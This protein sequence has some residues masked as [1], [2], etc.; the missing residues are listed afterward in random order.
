MH[1]FLSR[2]AFAASVLVLLPHSR[3]LAQKPARR[4]STAAVKARLVA[5]ISL[6]E[7]LRLAGEMHPDI[8]AAEADRRVAEGRLL[9]PA[10]A[11]WDVQIPPPDFSGF[12]VVESIEGLEKRLDAIP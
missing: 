2:A 3:L 9:D 8:R 4:E 7:A 10:G 5:R 6:P 11:R 1:S 12:P